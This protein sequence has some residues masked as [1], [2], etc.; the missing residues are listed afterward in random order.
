MNISV[1][2]SVMLKG[3]NTLPFEIPVSLANSTIRKDYLD[4]IKSPANKNALTATLT[5]RLAARFG[6][7]RKGE[8]IDFNT[9]SM[10]LEEEKGP[11]Y[12]F[13]NLSL[14]AKSADGRIQTASA[15]GSSIH[16]RS[17]ETP[18]ITINITFSFPAN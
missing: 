16:V 6:Q 11:S 5:N 18:K 10:W 9:V 12:V 1:G 13:G 17:V 7:M 2:V 14:S 15:A 8:N 3:G 4:G